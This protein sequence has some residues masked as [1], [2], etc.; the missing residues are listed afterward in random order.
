MHTSFVVSLLLNLALLSLLGFI[1]HTYAAEENEPVVNVDLVTPAPL[2]TAEPTHTPL[3]VVPP[4]ATVPPRAMHH[5]ARKPVV[6]VVT[7]VPAPIVASGP[8]VR[9]QASA[10]TED[11]SPRS[12]IP[13]ASNT[14]PP[15]PSSP[16]P[17]A[18]LPGAGGNGGGV[19][20]NNP[21]ART[22]RSKHVHRVECMGCHAAANSYWD[23]QPHPSEVENIIRTVWEPGGSP[24]QMEIVAT[25]NVSGAV[26]A[27]DLVHSSGDRDVDEALRAGIR[28]SRFDQPALRQNQ[29][30]EA[31]VRFIMDV[32]Y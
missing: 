32:Y 25:I 27:A 26:T 14:S 19:E 20:A 10:D 11:P 31:R 3:P 29:P 4:P 28:A 1:L 16:V 21:V 18:M 12:L 8:S 2:Q 17:Q 22:L 6:R 15:P 7:V 30:V 23:T 9:S 13:Q 24:H 5:V